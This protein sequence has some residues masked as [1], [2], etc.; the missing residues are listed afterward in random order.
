VLVAGGVAVDFAASVP[1][2]GCLVLASVVVFAAL[3]TDLSLARWEAYLMLVLYGAF[4]ALLFAE[5]VGSSR[6][7]IP[8]AG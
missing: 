7:L 5:G 3:R 8:T 4:L 2:L 6:L 1:L